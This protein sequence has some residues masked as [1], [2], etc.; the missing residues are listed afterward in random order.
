MIIFFIIILFLLLLWYLAPLILAGMG[1]HLMKNLGKSFG[2]DTAD[3][4]DQQEAR[5]QRGGG[6]SATGN[7]AAY[8]NKV[9]TD[10]EGTYIDFEE[11]KGEK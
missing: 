3:N 2:N 11:V 7:D 8:E 9:I 5:M 10:D 6:S 1:I 4:T